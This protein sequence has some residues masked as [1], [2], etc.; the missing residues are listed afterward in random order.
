MQPAFDHM[1]ETQINT[2]KNELPTTFLSLGIMVYLAILGV[3]LHDQF[4][5]SGEVHLQVRYKASVTW[6]LNYVLECNTP[7]NISFLTHVEATAR[8]YPQIWDIS[9]P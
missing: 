5:I 9:L 3:D 4:K 8:V 1:I 7:K 6:V 2:I